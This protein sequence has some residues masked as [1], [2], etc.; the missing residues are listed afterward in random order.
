MS[1]EVLK[2]LFMP[3]TLA[4][5]AGNVEEVIQLLDAHPGAI[6]YDTPMGS[7]L[8]MAASDGQLP[9][10]K[11]L[12]KRGIDVNAR[13]GTFKTNALY[14]AVNYGHLDVVKYLLE[15][16]SETDMSV[17]EKNPLFA[18]IHK[19]DNTEIAQALIDHGLDPH[20]D[21]GDDWNAISFAKQNGAQKILKLLQS[22]PK[23]GNAQ[24]EGK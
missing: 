7:W 21:Y 16:G 8:H 22:I 19:N 12:V 6:H 9:I 3:M 1:R 15:A 18:A 10:V 14:F 2:Q 5:R 17:S 23:K 20:H 13:G 11:E 4:I 24:S